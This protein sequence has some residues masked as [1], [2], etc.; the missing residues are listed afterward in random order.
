MKCHPYVHS[1]FFFFFERVGFRVSESEGKWRRKQHFVFPM[2]T[3]NYLRLIF[4]FQ[5]QNFTLEE[6]YLLIK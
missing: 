6:N 5:V 2:G 1:L 3:I 4:Q